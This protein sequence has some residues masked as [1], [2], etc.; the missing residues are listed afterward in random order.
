MWS[1]EE[2]L[3]ELCTYYN[4]KTT[5]QSTFRTWSENT[6]ITEQKQSE[7]IRAHNTTQNNQNCAI[8]YGSFMYSSFWLKAVD[9]IGNYSK[10]LLA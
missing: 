1:Y 2:M 7:G 8:C 6:W 10:W 4:V 9:T 5:W 3:H